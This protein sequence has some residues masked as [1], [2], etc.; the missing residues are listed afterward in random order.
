[1]R[2]YLSVWRQFNDF[3]MGLDSKPPRRWEDRMILFGAY[4]IEHKKI[5]SST[6][7]SYFS[8]IKCMLVDDDYNWDD[9]IVMFRTLTRACR[10]LN[11]KAS[12]RLPIQKGLLELL[13]FEIQRIFKNQYYL[14]ILYKTIFIVAYYGLFRIG[15]LTTG[16]HPVRAK[17]VY[18]ARNK[19]KLLMVL[20]SSKTHDSSMKPQK[21]KISAV[22]MSHDRGR[23]DNNSRNRIFCPFKISREYLALRGNYHTDRDPFFIFRD[24]SP[25]HP[26][27]VRKIL[28]LSLAGLNLNP[29]AY[30]T[31]SF[32][33]GRT[34]DLLKLG[35]PVEKIRLAGRWK[36]NIVNR[37]M[38]E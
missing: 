2:N 13:L 35:I 28:K 25:V 37:Y 6:L 14:E 15:E 21:V 18:I 38:T 31:H 34:L 3:L 12:T 11:D 32:R 36:S 10:N 1:M 19:D 5:Q 16:S 4:L 22:K 30:N 33:L 24:E 17:D 8:A 29:A 26:E 9:N 7:K 23:T 27:H 20:H